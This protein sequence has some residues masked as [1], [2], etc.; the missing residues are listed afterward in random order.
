MHYLRLVRS[1]RLKRGVEMAKKDW[2]GMP[3]DEFERESN[4]ILSKAGAPRPVKKK[5]AEL[6]GKYVSPVPG[7]KARPPKLGLGV[8][9]DKAWE[10]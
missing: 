4:K 10:K 2:L 7:G 1:Q 9:Y 6:G 8:G 3:S 5:L